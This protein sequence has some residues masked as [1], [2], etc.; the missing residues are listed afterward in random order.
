MN[1]KGI[2]ANEQTAACVDS[3]GIARIIG[4]DYVYFIQT[5]GSAPEVCESGKALQWNRGG[6]ALVV[7]KVRGNLQ[8]TNWFDVSDWVSG[9]G[10]VWQYWYV[11]NGVLTKTDA[12]GVP[13]CL[14][15]S[16]AFAKT[17]E[18][19]GSA[20]RSH[21]ARFIPVWNG[22]RI[23]IHGAIFDTR[24]RRLIPGHGRPQL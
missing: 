23:S 6:K 18:A 10:G 12:G 8:G 7:Y 13:P 4:P 2:G 16:V 5:C 20:H 15:S 19:S 11:Q 9:S 1:A 14:A 22:M 21:R 17:R 24:G 3:A